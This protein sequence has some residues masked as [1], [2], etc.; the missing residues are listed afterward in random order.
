M[1]L[2]LAPVAKTPEMRTFRPFGSMLDLMTCK[3]DEIL[4]DGPAGTGKSRGVLEKFHLMA[5]RYPGCRL[6]LVRKTRE[7]MTE[8]ILVTYEDKVLPVGHPAKSDVKRRYR[9]SYT[10]PNGSE[11]VIAGMDKPE[12]ILSTEYDAIYVNEGVE[13]D[14]AEFETLATR[15]RNGVIPYQQI[16]IDCNPEHPLHWL[17]QRYLK[18]SITRVQSTYKDNPVYWDHEHDTWT[19]L[20][21]SYVEGRLK[22][23]TGARRKRYYEGIWAASEGLIYE[24]NPSAHLI[25]YDEIPGLVKGK[26]PDDWRKLW[27][28]DFGYT[29][30]F[31]WWDLREDKHGRLY[32][33]REIYKTKRLIRDHAQF[34]KKLL[35]KERPPDDFICDWDAEGRAVL[36][37]QTGLKTTKA[38]KDISTGIQACEQRLRIREDG[39]PGI[40]LVRGALIEVDSELHEA[41]QPTCSEEEF[42]FYTWDTRK[43]RKAKELPIDEYNHG[44]DVFRYGV[45][46][47]DLKKRK[48]VR[49][50]G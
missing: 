20:G 32:R 40:M 2:E 44:M 45:A 43:G 15:L 8:S 26:I 3:D 27:V 23:L 36:E 17:W 46:R 18:G 7:S 37:E 21:L 29:K 9:Q 19:K 14:E 11:L 1:N 35:T 24:F 13:I 48:K 42:G 22:K 39:K 5:E 49:A 34:L 31:V 33:V 41:K 6:L 16:I 4:V 12:K 10:Y 47:I 28:V 25:D 30:P 50:V 38:F